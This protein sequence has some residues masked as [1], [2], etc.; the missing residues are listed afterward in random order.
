[1]R[2]YTREGEKK[3]LVESAELFKSQYDIVGA[4][5]KVGL[6]VSEH[7]E[8]AKETLALLMKQSNVLLSSSPDMRL[9][10]KVLNKSEDIKKKLLDKNIFLC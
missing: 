1:M 9:N 3:N 6:D 5:R 7:D 2:N 4:M 8:I 10:N